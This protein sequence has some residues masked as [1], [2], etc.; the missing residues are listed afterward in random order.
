MECMEYVDYIWNTMG[1]L[2]FFHYKAFADMRDYLIMGLSRNRTSR[3][4]LS[5]HCLLY[6]K[7]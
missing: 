2:A 4:M 3:G 5:Q 6:D 1:I 7:Q